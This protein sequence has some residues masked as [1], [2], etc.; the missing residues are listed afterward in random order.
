MGGGGGALRPVCPVLLT[1]V[2]WWRDVACH[3]S[4]IIRGAGVACF[5][6]FFFFFVL[7][8][9]QL[10]N[11]VSLR[12]KWDKPIQ[13]FRTWAEKKK[14]SRESRCPVKSAGVFVERLARLPILSM[15]C[16]SATGLFACTTLVCRKICIRSMCEVCVG[17][18]LSWQRRQPSLPPRRWRGWGDQRHFCQC[19]VVVI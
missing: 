2:V 6:F 19:S 5:S 13:G 10:R 18:F 1:C 9:P 15:S 12:V 4:K 3:F 11:V 7:R 16:C 8:R 17:L 14:K